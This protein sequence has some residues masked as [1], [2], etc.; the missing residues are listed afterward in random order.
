MS[1]LPPLLHQGRSLCLRRTAPADAS[2]LF[3]QMYRTAGFMRL[4]RLNDSVETEAQLKERLAQRLQVSPAQSGYLELL[5]L[6][7]QHGPLGVVC[8]ADYSALHRRAELLI[9]IFDENYRHASYGLEACLLIGDLAF[10]CYSLHRLY[11]YSY[12]YN[13]YAQKL[14]IA[15]GFDREGIMRS[16]VYD[17]EAQQFVDLHIYGMT[18]DQFRQNQRLARL[19]LRLVGRDI[20]Q[21][22]P[23]SAITAKETTQP[24]RPA[25]VRSGSITEI[26]HR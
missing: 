3:Q 12:E 8:L 15:G 20:T 10:N 1:D 24:K 19:S 18:V 16:H 2:L 5:I 26:L 17:R 6:H 4:F 13:H 7:R 23:P 9:G 22:P 14:M 11:A 21:L 25:F